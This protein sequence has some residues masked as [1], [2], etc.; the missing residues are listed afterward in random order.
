MTAVSWMWAVLVVVTPIIAALGR[1]LVSLCRHAIRSASI[2]RMV[3][4]R[5]RV[6]RI[7]DRITEGDLLEIEVLPSNE[8]VHGIDPKSA[9]S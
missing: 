1:G 7:V 4:H 8:W 5:T 3:R 6:I 2:R 9:G